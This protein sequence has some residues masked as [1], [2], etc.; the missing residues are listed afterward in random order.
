M[1]FE[2]SAYLYFSACEEIYLTYSMSQVH[3]VNSSLFV[4]VVAFGAAGN[5]NCAPVD[6]L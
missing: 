6:R 3:E 2:V 4:G 5:V 1:L